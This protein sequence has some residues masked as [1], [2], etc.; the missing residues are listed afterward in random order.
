MIDSAG[1]SPVR[2]PA[3]GIAPL[4]A[5]RSHGAFP[6]IR[7]RISSSVV[8]E[9]RL[10]RPGEKENPAIADSLSRPRAEPNPKT[11][12][13]GAFPSQTIRAVR[14]GHRAEGACVTPLIL[15]SDLFWFLTGLGCDLG[16]GGRVTRRSLNRRPRGLLAEREPAGSESRPSVGV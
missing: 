13:H 8:G 1:V 9:E 5:G 3:H 16:Q 6:Q 4:S 2:V 11:P 14:S 7:G 12:Q 15:Q 10:P